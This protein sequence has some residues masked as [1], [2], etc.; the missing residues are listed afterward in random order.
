MS[1]GRSA[2]RH[3]LAR[4]HLYAK[5]DLNWPDA[6][7]LAAQG[8]PQSKAVP[9]TAANLSAAAAPGDSV[10]A[11]GV[12]SRVH[13]SVI[14]CRQDMFLVDGVIIKVSQCF[15]SEPHQLKAAADNLTP[16]GKPPPVVPK[17]SWCDI[18]GQCM[19]DY[20]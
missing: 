15:F 2:A 4:K 12:E 7:A 14:I 11:A 6:E 19:G 8:K 20:F 5:H 3:S 18:A 16:A 13:C 1:A 10:P 9:V 17:A